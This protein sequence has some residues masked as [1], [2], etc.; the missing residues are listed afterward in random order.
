MQQRRPALEARDGAEEALQLLVGRAV[1][2]VGRVKLRVAALQQRRVERASERFDLVPAHSGA[3][4]PGVDAQVEGPAFTPQAH[5]RPNRV[6]GLE[7]RR[8][9]V[10]LVAIER[11]RT[12]RAEDQHRARDA[13]VPQ[14]DTLGER[15]DAEAPRI[16]G[17]ERPGDSDGSDP[18][19]V[20]LHHGE[21]PC[22]RGARHRPGIFHHGGEADFDPGAARPPD[23]G[24]THRRGKLIAA[25]R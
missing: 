4:H 1:A 6:G 22:A 5:P 25:R 10:A 15:G 12:R 23:V 24:R 20:G 9:P 7:H 17:V 14:L 8:E 18:V 3:A 21:E 11:L 19:R 2:V 16:H 13:G